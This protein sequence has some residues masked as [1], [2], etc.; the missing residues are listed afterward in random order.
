MNTNTRFKLAR[1]ASRFTQ[2]EL[3]ELVGLPEY[4]VT[5]IETGRTVP[6]TEMKTKLAAALKKPSFELFAE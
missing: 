4:Q 5:R 3:G 1:I 6:D 2:R